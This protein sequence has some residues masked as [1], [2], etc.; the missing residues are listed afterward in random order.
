MATRQRLQI[1]KATPADCRDIWLWRNDPVTRAQSLTKRRISYPRHKKWF[2]GT[3][4]DRRRF[5]CIAFQNGRKVGMVRLDFHPGDVAEI[6]VNIRPEDRGRGLG[7]KILK[8]ADRLLRKQ[9]KHS[10]Q[11]AIIKK[12]NIASEKAFSAAGYRKIHESED[13]GYSVWIKS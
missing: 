6:S 2:T 9:K 4:K 8:L 5:L 11:K 12:G 13:Q 3:L 7:K 10:V 1:R